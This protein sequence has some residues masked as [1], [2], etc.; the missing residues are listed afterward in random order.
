MRRASLLATLWL[1][2][3]PVVMLA[4]CTG[5][6][7]VAEQVQP[8]THPWERAIP[9]Q[10]VPEGLESLRAADCGECHRQIYQE[11]RGSVHARALSD[12][13]FQAEWAKDG[14]LF[15]CRN[16]HTPLQNQQETIVAGLVAGDY[17]RPAQH[18]N[19]GFEAAL[20][21]EA[22]TCAV[23]H[24][25]AG[26]VIG[27]YG[28]TDAPHPVRRDPELLSAT[29]CMTCHNVQ[30]VLSATLICSFTTGD[31]W[32]AS[33]YPTQG[34]DC[35][36]CHMP[37]VERADVEGQ[38]PRASNRHT[39]A[40]GGIAKHPGDEAL[41]RREYAPGLEVALESAQR[42]GDSLRVAVRLTNARAGHQL[43]TGD[44]E[45]FLAVDLELLGSD[46]T[47]LA[48]R[49]ER[50][51]E[52]WEWWPEARQVSDNS[53]APLESRRFELVGPAPTSDG[54]ARLRLVVTHHRMTE[55]NARAMGV[56][57]RYP[58]AAESVR[59]EF[60]IR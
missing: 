1:G 38:V 25:R 23:C 48:A 49:Q 35:V 29:G 46:A 8:L 18:P 24:V 52:V 6:E 53:L 33:P 43:P 30:G 59:T 60:T 36:A 55:E 39:W 40:G 27:P 54:P 3:A 20:E 21:E 16:C 15:V 17:G 12:P 22:I 28:D 10:A 32:L 58:L 41:A 14:H 13:Q 42:E 57:G 45:R 37:E 2:M 4:A 50:I 34:K 51:G 7:P 31:E 19:P 5:G 11:W 47:V 56:L 44:V 9:Q 26:I